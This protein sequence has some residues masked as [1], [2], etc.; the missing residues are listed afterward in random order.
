MG[1]RDAVRDDRSASEADKCSASKSTQNWHQCS[2]R[3]IVKSSP[4][5]PKRAAWAVG[6]DAVAGG[7]GVV[8][9]PT[10]VQPRA[11]LPSSAPSFGT[12]FCT[13]AASSE[14][15]MVPLALVSPLRKASSS[16]QVKTPCPL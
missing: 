16:A 2:R 14:S 9:G 12:K 15:S 4:L 13:W 1:L 11:G 5:D 7:G 3:E 6:G 10:T 8:A